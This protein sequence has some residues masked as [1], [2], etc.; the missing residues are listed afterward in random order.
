MTDEIKVAAER[1]KDVRDR[2]H[3][4]EDLTPETLRDLAVEYINLLDCEAERALPVTVEWL[5][6]LC[7]TNEG[8]S[9]YLFIEDRLGIACRNGIFVVNING[10][11][12]TI[13]TRGQIIDLCKVT[14][15][16]IEKYLSEKRDGVKP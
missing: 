2:W 6:P 3:R 1:L 14:G 9:R 15:F 11:E 13:T 7:V 8:L 16:D 12:S 4:G 5:E 10:W